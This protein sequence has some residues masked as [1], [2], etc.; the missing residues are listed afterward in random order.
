MDCPRC[1]SSRHVKAGIVK[2]R[3]RYRC[4]GYGYHYTVKKRSPRIPDSIKR[5][6]VQLHLEG[7]GFRSIERLLGVS[8]VS[9]MNWVAGFAE[10][11]APLRSPTKPAAAE[12]DELHGYVGRK[13]NTA[14]FGLL[15]IDFGTGSSIS[16]LATE[17]QRLVE[18]F[19]TP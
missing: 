14:G 6:A 13:K 19:G 8:H 17:A 1:D 16:L 4:K 11:F 15:L 10:R 12:I 5:F 18:G 9:V 3:Q 7:L 2:Q